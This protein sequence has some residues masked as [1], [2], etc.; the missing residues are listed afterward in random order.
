MSVD[1]SPA[2][3]RDPRIEGFRRRPRSITHIS[4]DATQKE[5]AEGN[6]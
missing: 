1:W 2:A 4:G 5:Q 6:R 3:A